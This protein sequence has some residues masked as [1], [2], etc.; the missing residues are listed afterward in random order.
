MSFVAAIQSGFR[1]YANFKGRAG[2][3]EFWWW[4]L[5]TLL[6][7]AATSGFGDTINGLASLVV[8]LPSLAVHVRRLHDTNR[9]GWWMAAPLVAL[10]VAVIVF[11]A[12]GVLTAFDIVDGS[13]WDPATAFDGVSSWALTALGISLLAALVTG[14]INL[15]FLLQRSHVTENRFGPPPPPRA[16]S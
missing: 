12:F 9:S 1:N 16:V 2:R 4:T 15:V 6:L 7:Q 13:E 11:V 10:V 5:F 3:G 8:L 14:V